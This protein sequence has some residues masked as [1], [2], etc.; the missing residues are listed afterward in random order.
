MS[1]HINTKGKSVINDVLK[2]LKEGQGKYFVNIYTEDDY[3]FITE[4]DTVTVGVGTLLIKTN[5]NNKLHLDLINT[6]KIE[7]VELCE[8]KE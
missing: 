7:R 5:K 2:V 4:E 8:S 3:F 1:W 6:N